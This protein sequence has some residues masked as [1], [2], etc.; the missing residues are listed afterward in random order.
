MACIKFESHPLVPTNH[1]LNHQYSL[2]SQIL[3]E[4]KNIDGFFS[5]DP[6]YHGVECD[7]GACPPNT[8]TAVNQEGVR[9]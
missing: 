1:C 5:F 7:E 2:L 9:L 3:N 8:S 6:L 4:L